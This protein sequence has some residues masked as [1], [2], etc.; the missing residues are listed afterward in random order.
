M[1]FS[2]FVIFAKILQVV[3]FAKK[4]LLISPK[5]LKISSNLKRI[6]IK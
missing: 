6:K 2:L 1:G 4:M 3:A 5:K